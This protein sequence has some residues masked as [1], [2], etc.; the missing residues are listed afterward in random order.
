MWTFGTLRER[1]FST[2]CRF[3]FMFVCFQHLLGDSGV[4][5]IELNVEKISELGNTD[6]LLSTISRLSKCGVDV[7]GMKE[8]E[9]NMLPSNS[10]AKCMDGTNAGY[11][12]LMISP[13]IS[14]LGGPNVLRI[15]G[16]QRHKI[17]IIFH[18]FLLITSEKPSFK[19][20]VWIYMLQSI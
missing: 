14:W 17:K 16:P 6:V 1:Q 11:V 2:F 13:T 7:R 12:D 3:L 4:D 8:L 18:V 20:L 5:E 9:R 10:S 19:C 15:C